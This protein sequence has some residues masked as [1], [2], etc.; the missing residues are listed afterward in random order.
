MQ[1][2]LGSK[3]FVGAI[4]VV[5][6][7]VA[8]GGLIVAGAPSQERARQ[9]D[10]RRISDL[11]Q[12]SQAIDQYWTRNAQLP[13]ALTDMQNRREYYIPSL[14]DP[15]TQEP[16]EYRITAGKSYELCAT[17]ETDSSTDPAQ[18]NYSQ[19]YPVSGGVNFW[20]HGKGRVC[21]TIEA[22][23]IPGLV[24]TAKNVGL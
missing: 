5:V 8:I 13:Q 11:Q 23:D 4:V 2:D 6:A 12:F 19:P 18:T 14:L 9:F 20:A 15:R 10:S 17:F 7:A 22:Q 1:K 16:Y 24:P 3:I 21:F